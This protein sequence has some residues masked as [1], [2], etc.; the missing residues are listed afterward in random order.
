[1]N[2]QTLIPLKKQASNLI[3]YNS[4]SLLF[5][6]CFSENI[7]DKFEYF[8]FQT[9][10]NPFGIL[11]HPLAIENLITRA[12]NEEY[13]SEADLHFH[14]EQWY[15]LDAH[16]KL[17]SISKNDLVQNL[18]DQIDSTNAQLKTATHIIITLGTSW[19]Y[20][21]IT[22]DAIVANCH[23]L[24]QKQ[25][26][27]ALLSVDDITK[28]L[29]SI[30]TLVKRVN[31]KVIFIFTVSPVRHI[32]DGF[33]ENTQSKSH[34]I[35]AIHSVLNQNSII[36]NCQLFY[37]PSYE[38]IMDELRDYRFYNADMLHPNTIAID[39]IWEKFKR[40]WFSEDTTET[41]RKVDSI[42][43]DLAHKPFNS[44]SEAHKKFKHK[45][46]TK[47]E[48]LQKAYPQFKTFYKPLL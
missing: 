44:N 9:T 38:I 5:G 4:S 36:K 33:I 40:V 12:I 13:Y 8:K 16:S 14:N 27:K 41:M 17:N 6:S 43:R 20:R 7:G 32:K 1:M 47:I 46:Q 29:E 30:I 31:P 42:Q 28:S 35:T 24:P 10:I 39:Y 15:C 2:L 25:F 45:L 11:F 37:F 22:S 21:H 34:L 18:N 23:K 19:V 48:N 26:T 3:G